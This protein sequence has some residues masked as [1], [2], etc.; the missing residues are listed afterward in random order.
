MTVNNPQVML[1]FDTRLL[2]LPD[3]GHPWELADADSQRGRRPG[4]RTPPMFAMDQRSKVRGSV[5][6]RCWSKGVVSMRRSENRRCIAKCK[7]L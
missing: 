6:P 2:V 3:C 1:R 7:S 4:E 5:V